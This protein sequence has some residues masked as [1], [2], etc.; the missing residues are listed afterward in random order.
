MC[1]KLLLNVAYPA[2]ITTK[3]NYTL[4]PTA[5]KEVFRLVMY[6]AKADDNRVSESELQKPIMMAGLTVL[7]SRSRC[8]LTTAAVAEE[9]NQK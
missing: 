1:F 4:Q 8:K 3:V 7:F 2:D 6:S 5:E 9:E